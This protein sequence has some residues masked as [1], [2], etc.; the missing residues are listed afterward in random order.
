MRAEKYHLN[1][2]TALFAL[3]IPG[4]GPVVDLWSPVITLGDAKCLDLWENK[5]THFSYS[6]NSSQI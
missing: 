3:W 4:G 5:D 6:S 2:L 1:R